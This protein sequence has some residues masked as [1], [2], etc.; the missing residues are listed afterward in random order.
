MIFTYK[1][2]PRIVQHSILQ[3][4]KGHSSI[5]VVCCQCTVCLWVRQAIAAWRCR[6]L[7]T[8]RPAPLSELML[9]LRI[10]VGSSPL[11]SDWRQPWPWVDS[12]FPTQNT[13]FTL[14]R[15]NITTITYQ[16]MVSCLVLLV[17]ANISI[18]QEN[19]KIYCLSVVSL[20]FP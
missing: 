6:E 7:G 12:T 2:L 9:L 14:C 5:E 13:F 3:R 16:L 8:W 11:R 1:Y 17:I 18:C 20:N 19:T 4:A 15:N 10:S